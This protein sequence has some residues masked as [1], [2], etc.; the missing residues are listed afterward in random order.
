MRSGGAT[1]RRQRPALWHGVSQGHAL[2]QPGIAT[3]MT[4][5]GAQVLAE[6]IVPALDK[7]RREKADYARY[8]QARVDLDRQGQ[9]TIA[10]TYSLQQR[11]GIPKPCCSC[12]S[13]LWLQL[14]VAVC[15]QRIAAQG[16]K[17][18]PIPCSYRAR[19]LGGALLFLGLA[20]LCFWSV[21]SCADFLN[22]ANPVLC[23]RLSQQTFASGQANL[24]IWSES[25]PF[26]SC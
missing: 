13:C 14:L 18:L 10:H 9:F 22:V 12:R 21:C 26:K 7:L 17:G 25:G 15:M 24:H 5:T 1:E 8:Q 2:V 19:W 4:A 6:D 20:G 11:C 23:R 3:R 16:N